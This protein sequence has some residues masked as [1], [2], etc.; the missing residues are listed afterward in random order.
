MDKQNLFFAFDGDDVGKRHAQAILSD[1]VGDISNV[2]GGITH[3]NETIRDYVESNGGR[4]ISFG[5]DEGIFEAPSDFVSRL[6]QLRQDYQSM[7]GATLSIGYGAKPSEAAKALIEAKETGKD[8]IIGYSENTEKYVQPVQENND[9]ESSTDDENVGHDQV[10]PEGSDSV[11]NEPTLCEPPKNDN[12]LGYDS[13]YKN[14]NIEDRTQSY[15][16]NDLEPPSIQKPNLIAQA[17]ISEAPSSDIQESDRN[18]NKEL[19]DPKDVPAIEQKPGDLQYTSNK[20]DNNR[21]PNIPSENATTDVA[22]NTEEQDMLGDKHCASCTCEDHEQS[23]EDTLNQHV[24]N[25][26]D[27]SDSLGDGSNESAEDTLDTH[28]ENAADMDS[29]IDEHGISRPEDYDENQ[30]DLGLSE[31]E[32]DN[33]DEPNINDVLKD[34]L[35]SHAENIKR[36]KVLNMVGEALEGFKSQKQ[37]L[38]KAKDQAPELYDSCISMLKAMIELCS[39][40]GIDQGQAEQDVNEIEGQ[41]ESPEEQPGSEGESEESC[42][43]CGHQEAAP[44]EGSQ[45]PPQQ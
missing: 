32:A 26:T 38:D 37:I 28:I 5:G 29:N 30:G 11:Q 22:E 8:K 42:P 41:S 4:M 33:N 7:V 31:E 18:M 3:A 27:F 45:K 14:S 19:P 15:R 13:G 21:E 6:E 20:E 39:L 12:N 1:N 44:K 10:L 16:A 43:N 35:D 34:G 2:S 40:A 25:A 17:R 36:E 9:S 24:D 23:N